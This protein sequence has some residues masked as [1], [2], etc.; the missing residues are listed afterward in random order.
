MSFSGKIKEELAQHYAKS[1]D[2]AILR[3]CLRL[4]I[5]RALLRK[6]AMGAAY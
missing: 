4:S 1:K 6:M 2:T 5:C 3:N